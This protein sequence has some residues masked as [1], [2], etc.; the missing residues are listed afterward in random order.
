MREKAVAKLLRDAKRTAQQDAEAVEDLEARLAELK[1]PVSERII[2]F[3]EQLKVPSGVGKG[4]RLRLRDW[5]KDLIR[6]T[7][8][9]I[10]ED[11]TRRVR[12]GLWS[13]ARKNGK[14]AIVAA[15]LLCALVGPLAQLNGE[16][17]SAATDRNQA[18]IIYK[19]ASQMIAMDEEL[20][21]MCKCV[22]TQ[23]RIVCYHLNAY[24]VALSADAHR[25]H[26]ANPHF[27][28][29]DELA[30][31]KDR[32]LYDVLSTSFDAQ[33]NALLL[34]IST[35]S[36]DP[37]SIMSE[38]ADDAILQEKGML[39]DPYFFGMVFRLDVPDDKDAAAALVWDET[40]WFEANP[41]L[42]DFKLLQGMRSQAVKAKR[43]PAAAAAFKNL[44]LNMR[45]DGAASFVNSEDWRACEGFVDDARLIDVA[46]AGGL[47]LSGRRD[48]T[49]LVLLFDLGDEIAV[50]SWFWTPEE[51]LDE[52]SKMDGAQYRLWSEQGHLTV[53]P[54]PVID[55]SRVA[56]DIVAIRKR[57]NISQ[58]AFDRWR[59]AE[60]GRE[61]TKAGLD[62]EALPMAPHGQGFKDMGPAVDDLADLVVLRKLRHGGNPVLTYCMANVKVVSD[63][64][65]NRKFDKRKKNKRIDGAIALAQACTSMNRPIEKEVK[66]PSVYEDRGVM[67]F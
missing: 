48:L 9:P 12:R 2:A 7:F 51:G 47:D 26:G 60:F 61:L 34:V 10:N 21:Q 59:I 62:E 52:R 16:V 63:P 37:T 53:I 31:A 44:H 54:G 65:D 23:K 13:M 36:S 29:Y 66:G 58:I 4:G 46:G 25:Q 27:V 8:D 18:A 41:A 32:E 42:D 11:G 5:Q 33:P 14:T 40:Q 56:S 15:L 17:Y 20:S 28:I 45:V 39:E 50:R 3:I 1:K 64:A 57:Y 30:Q 24:Y 43:N 35:Q 67:S 19:M 55:Y 22:D 38:L 49:S 6:C